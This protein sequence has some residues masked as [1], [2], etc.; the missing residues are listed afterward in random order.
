LATLCTGAGSAKYVMTD[1]QLTIN[2]S[3]YYNTA[4]SGIDTDE[5]CAA[6]N[7]N[8]VREFLRD[9][10][11]PIT[12]IDTDEVCAAD[13]NNKVREFLDKNYTCVSALILL[14]ATVGR[15]LLLVVQ[16]VV[17]VGTF[18]SYNEALQQSFS[19]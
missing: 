8:K 9:K 19:K 17:I 1:P 7:N 10:L 4:I 15:C 18:S 3:R 2:I 13:N 11:M 6:D 12:G 14:L 16:C 5:V